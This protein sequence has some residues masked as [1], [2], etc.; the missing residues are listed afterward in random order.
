MHASVNVYSVK[1]LNI[2]PVASPYFK[3]VNLM[4]CCFVFNSS[5]PMLIKSSITIWAQCFT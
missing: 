3:I 4:L 5:L 2:L 1:N